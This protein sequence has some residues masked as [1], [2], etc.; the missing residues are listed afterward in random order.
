MMTASAARFI[1]A[2]EAAILA[3]YGVDPFDPAITPRRMWVL[4]TNL[5]PG[6]LAGEHAGSWT[7][8]SYLLASVLDA[9]NTLTWVQVAKSSKS[10]PKRPKPTPRPGQPVQQKR[11]MR[12]AELAGALT[13]KPGIQDGS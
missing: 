7:I 1:P 4:L 3:H 8:E 10:K 12:L 13:G 6:S 11:G 9:I 5:P 2:T